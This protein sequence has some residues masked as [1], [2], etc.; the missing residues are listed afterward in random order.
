MKSLCTSGYRAAF[1]TKLLLLG[2]MLAVPTRAATLTLTNINNTVPS[3]L[4]TNPDGSITITGGGGDTYDN[5]DSFTYYYETRTGDFDVQVQ[6]ISVDADDPTGAQQSAKAS[7]HVRANLTPGSP[8]IQVSG[9]PTAGANYVETIFRP[10]QD[11]GTD[12][13]PQN[14]SEFVHYGDGPWDGTFRPVNEGELYP[15]WVRVKREGNLFQTFYSVDGVHWPVLAEY[16]VDSAQFPE[17]INVGLAAV[18]HVGSGEDENLRVRSTFKDYHD[19]PFPPATTVN[20]APAGDDA[21]GPFPNTSVSAVNWTVSLPA[22]GIGFSADLTE[23]GPIV[24]NTGGFGTISRDIL[25]SIDGQQGPIPFSISRYACGALDLGISPQDPVA[26]QENLGPYSNPK[27]IRST[28]QATS[29][30]AQAWFP[31]PRYGVLIPTVRTNGPIQWN[32]GAAPFYPHTFQVIDFSSATYFNL[33]DG[34]FG[35]GQPYTRMSKLGDTRAH[36][37]PEANSAGGFQRAAFDISVAWFPFSQG[38]QAGYFKDATQGPRAFW[39][40]PASHSP[41]ASVDTLAI[42]K[43]SASALL[44]WVDLVGDQTFGGLAELSFPGV[45]SRDGGLLFV[46]PNDDNTE[47]GPQANAAIKGDGTGWTVAIRGVQENKTD[48]ATYVQ[49]NQSEFSFLLIPYTA[50]NLIG[51]EIAGATGAKLHSAG[52]FTVTRQEAGRYLL[53]IP[54]KQSTNGMLILQPVGTLPDNPNLVDNVTMTYAPSANGFVIESRYIAPG[55]GENGFDA[56]PLRDSN[57]YFAW[58]DFTNPLTPTAAAVPP[59]LSVQTQGTSVVVSWP[60]GVTGWTLQSSPSLSTPDWQPVPGVVNNSV[61][62][63][64]TTGPS[65]FRL[66]Q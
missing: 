53:S 38:W 29:A 31:S 60:A 21:P 56:F 20:G 8:D 47:R 58:V 14:A 18:A 36:P 26:A 5:A 2:L 64:P 10:V 19:T 45:D 35:N 17:T 24:W 48:P 44:T 15:V 55:A 3:T 41:A 40:D 61:T 11:G 23:S 32:D 65:F 33:D 30:P 16:S 42:N 7:L 46:T 63:T 37:N 4:V 62:L 9:T 66:S 1:L 52:E 43:N 59:T 13:P 25:L 51:G 27:R 34:T 57:F 28:P 22:D 12:D 6:L 50:G 39:H 54:G 49:A